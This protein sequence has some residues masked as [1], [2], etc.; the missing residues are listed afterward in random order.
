MVR[1]VLLAALAAAVV[2]LAA[3]GDDDETAKTTSLTVTETQP[4]KNRFVVEGIKSVPSG[5]VKLDFTNNAKGPAELQLVRIDSGHSKDEALKILKQDEGPIPAWFH[6]AGG[7]GAIKPGTSGTTTE[8]LPPGQYYALDDQTQDQ[9]DPSPSE[10]G[11]L[12][13]FE[14]TG[15]SKSGDLPA[16]TATVAAKDKGDDE[17]SWDV[18]GLKAG[19]NTLEFANDSKEELHHLVAFPLLPGKSADD[20][21]K[22]LATQGKPSGPPPIDFEGGQTTSVLDQKTKEVTTLELAKPGNYVLLC[23]LGDRDG[24]GKSHFQE[25]LIKEVKVQ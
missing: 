12:V 19:K 5:P 22:F 20:A 6:A 18:S 25:G 17:F 21:E 9:G 11:A 16:S 14:V 15:D 7:V 4:A 13:A 24:K 1:G 10:M 23:F 2:G 8:V 3:C